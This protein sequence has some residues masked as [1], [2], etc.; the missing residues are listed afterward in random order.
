MYRVG[1]AVAW[2]GAER[3]ASPG[4]AEPFRVRAFCIRI[5]MTGVRRQPFPIQLHTCTGRPV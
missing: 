1:S 2:R 5:V 3:G 4:H